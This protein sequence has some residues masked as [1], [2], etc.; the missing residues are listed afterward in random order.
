MALPPE[1]IAQLQAAQKTAQDR[2]VNQAKELINAQDIGYTSKLFVQALFPYRKTDEE[3]RV[4]ETAQGRIVV[5]ADGGLPYG[6][7]PRLIM[8]YIVTRA[9][10]NAGKLKAGKIDLE[11][12]VRIPLGHSMNHFLQAKELADKL[13]MHYTFGANEPKDVGGEEGLDE[14][15]YGLAILSKMKIK[16]SENTHL[17]FDVN[18]KASSEENP[19]PEQRGLLRA[20]VKWNGEKVDLYS[21]HWEHKWDS[22]RERQADAAATAIAKRDMPSIV[23][24]DLN[25]EPDDVAVNAL[26][27]GAVIKDA[28]QTLE[29][30]DPTNDKGQHI[31]YVLYSE[32]FAPVDGGPVVNDASDHYPV[33]VTF[34]SAD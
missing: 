5:Y 4:I 11:Q 16:D 1:K 23:M 24:G 34:K 33:A 19:K 20:T 27:G 29:V 28:L 15:G 21:T 25:A 30:E 31:D 12:A 2:E 26:L 13:D 14:E 10:E 32:A 18:G 6:K 8:A 22:L 3:K 17:P 9:V 7:Y